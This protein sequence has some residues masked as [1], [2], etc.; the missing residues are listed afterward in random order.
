MAVEPI[1]FHSSQYQITTD[2]YQGPLDLLLQLIE[3]AELDIT[4]LSLA[5]VTDQFLEYV[6]QME[7]ERP[8]EVSAFV[9]IA[10]R[11]IQIKAAAL[12]PKSVVSANGLDEDSG[13]ALARQLILY[14]RFKQ[15]ADSLNEREDM[16]LRSMLRIGTPNVGI[17]PAPDLS[18]V[19]VNTL[20]EIAARVFAVKAPS[21]SLRTVMSRPRLTIREKIS[22][23]VRR[24]QNGKP[25]RFSSLL[26]GSSKTEAVVTFLAMLEMIKQNAVH[27]RQESIFGDIEIEELAPIKE[28]D[29]R[30]EFGD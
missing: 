12:L 14:R 10:A 22:L 8:S 11:L 7:E 16:G 21:E 13:E 5:Q 6:R 25:I 26:E 24:L 20:A 27:I 17:E 30:S 9:V 29:I 23:L 15:L 19:T 28:T 18:G 1:Y 4:V 3:K 2:V